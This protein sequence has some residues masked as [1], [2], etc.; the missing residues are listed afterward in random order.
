MTATLKAK[1]T[2]EPHPETK[3]ITDMVQQS[4]GR[5]CMSSTFFDDFYNDFT[6]TSPKVREKFAKTDFV[7]QKKALRQGLTFVVM[8][9]SGASLA[10]KVIKELGES[11]N[12][13]HLNI[14]PE[15]YQFWTDA[16]LRTVKKND[17]N[18]NPQ[19]EDAWK[20]VLAKAVDAIKSAY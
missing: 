12:R 5:C 10:G 3:L 4:Y 9:Y 6:K 18:M 11:H 1:P 20:K 15:L 14:E 16:L 17:R 7:K 8:Y 13:Q 2:N 19:L